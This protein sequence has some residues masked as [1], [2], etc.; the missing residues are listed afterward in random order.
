MKLGRATR[1]APGPL[2]A[3]T[4]ILPVAGVDVR[5]RAGLELDASV[6]RLIV[7]AAE[8]IIT[9]SRLV[10]N[11]MHHVA[12]FNEAELFREL[13]DEL[14]RELEQPSVESMGHLLDS[15]H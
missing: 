15:Q 10:A 5:Q 9:I 2:H 8:L 7:S 4:Y 3:L 6:R 13:A 14:R 11:T 12:G 1:T